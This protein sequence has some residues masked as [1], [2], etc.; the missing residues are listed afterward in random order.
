[1]L[2]QELL[3]SS[4]IGEHISIHHVPLNWPDARKLIEEREPQ[5]ALKAAVLKHQ[6]WI[7]VLSMGSHRISKL[8]FT[9]S[10]ALN[11]PALPSFVQ[12][13]LAGMELVNGIEE[14]TKALGRDTQNILETGVIGGVGTRRGSPAKAGRPP[15][16]TNNDLKVF[17]PPAKAELTAEWI[18][19]EDPS[20]RSKTAADTSPNFRSRGP[21]HACVK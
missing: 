11:D 3:P 18:E 2:T 15:T 17:A 12:N 7:P 20:P 19:Y 8:S 16:E 9:D 13:V 21:G 5:K 6:E 1:M 4:L 14:G 10:G